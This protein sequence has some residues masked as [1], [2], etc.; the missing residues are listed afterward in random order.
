LSVEVR[1]QEKLDI[2]EERDFRREELPGKYMAKM[3]Y[4]WNDR[5]LKMSTYLEV[6]EELAKME[7]SF[8]REETLKGE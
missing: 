8:S 5:K 4:G 7:V 3:L 6:R 2:V 1:K